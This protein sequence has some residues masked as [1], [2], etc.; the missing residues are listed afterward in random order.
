MTSETGVAVWN[1]PSP[2]STRVEYLGVREVEGPGTM[3]STSG[4]STG[5]S[6]SVSNGASR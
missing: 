6:S 1:P 4:S 3:S 2:T 5:S